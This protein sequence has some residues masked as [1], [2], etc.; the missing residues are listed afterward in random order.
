M[1]DFRDNSYNLLWQ[2]Y[3]VFCTINISVYLLLQFY[4]FR[5]LHFFMKPKK[6]SNKFLQTD[7]MTHHDNTI[8]YTKTFLAIFR[9]YPYPHRFFSHVFRPLFQQLCISI[10]LCIH[11]F[12]RCLLPFRGFF[13]CYIIGPFIL[14]PSA[15]VISLYLISGDT[16]PDVET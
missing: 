8:T 12:I 14:T 1:Y 9:T 13:K 6:W 7:I 5:L 2:P 3:F 4:L 11:F 10:T 15:S 16:T